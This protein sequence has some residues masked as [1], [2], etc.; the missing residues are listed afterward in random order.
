MQCTKH[1]QRPCSQDHHFGA[2]LDIRIPPINKYCKKIC[3]A[4]QL[5]SWNLIIECGQDD[6]GYDVLAEE[7]GEGEEGLHDLARPPLHTYRVVGK[8]FQFLKWK[9]L[10]QQSFSKPLSYFS[11]FRKGEINKGNNQNKK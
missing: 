8:G 1:E 6:E 2:T 11:P 3:N 5:K 9:P 4:I 10:Q 7:D